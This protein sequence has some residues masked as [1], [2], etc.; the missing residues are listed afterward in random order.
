MAITQIETKAYEQVISNVDTVRPRHR[1]YPQLDGMRALAVLLVLFHHMDDLDVPHPMRY[2]SS[3]G[4]VGVDAFFVLSGFLIT[5]I[6]LSSRP[7]IRAYSLFLLRRTLRTWPLYFTLLLFAFLF[8]R[9]TPT[10]VNVNWLRC[11]FFLH[12]YEPRFV[13]RT[14]GPTWSLCV[15]EHFYLIWP[16]L[17]FLLPRRVLAGAIAVLLVSCPA[18]RYWGLHASF[19]YKQIYSETQFHL[20]SLLAGSFVA[21]LMTSRFRFRP[22]TMRWTAYVCLVVGAA[23]SI[24]NFWHG[25][26]AEKP[27]MLF[28]FTT[29]AVFFSGLLLLLITAESSALCKLF[30]LGPVRYVGRISYGIYLLHDGLIAALERVGRGGVIG[31][32]F[33]NWAFAIPLRIGIAIGVASLSYRFFESPILR[34]KDRLH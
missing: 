19:T 17:V 3:L 32:L 24:A 30:S 2:F 12:N 20:D 9:N 6:L 16:F 7:G 21:L 8:F 4:W 34:L 22:P 18:V 10:G 28:G 23:G 14:L 13:A 33:H 15:E 1:F 26:S 27:T 5:S 31:F 29:L 25:W 11:A